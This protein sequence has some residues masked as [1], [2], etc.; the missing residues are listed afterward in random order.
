M[1]D[2]CFVHRGIALVRNFL[3]VIHAV[4][5]GIPWMGI[6]QF[7]AVV[8]LSWIPSRSVSKAA[9]AGYRYAVDAREVGLCP[10]LPVRE[11]NAAGTA[12][13]VGRVHPWQQARPQKTVR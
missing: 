1:N 11:V 2:D 4:A 6:G 5:V 12:G 7:G 13:T 9:G 8:P 10:E 3:T